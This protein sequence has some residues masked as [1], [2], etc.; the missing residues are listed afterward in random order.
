MKKITLTLFSLLFT[1]GLFAQHQGIVPR[2][3]QIKALTERTDPAVEITLGEITNT[4][5][6]AG[7]AP[8]AACASYFILMDEQARME[9][10]SGMFGVPID[11]LVH[12]WGI[13]KT[14]AYTHLWIE[15]FAGTEYT[16]YVSPVDA[17]GIVFP[18]QT[19]VLTTLTGGGSGVAEVDVQVSEITATTAR[20]IATPN[21]ETALFH[22][23]LIT[24]DYYNEIGAEAAIEFFKSEPPYYQ[25]DDYVWPGLNPAT[26][27]YALAIGQNGEGEWGSATLV[28]FTT[29]PLVGILNH[30]A[31]PSTI[32][33]FPSPG[34]GTFTFKSMNGDNGKIR[35]YNINGQMVHE[36]TVSGSESRINAG[37]LTNG[38][39]QL[40][41]TSEKSAEIATQKLIIS[42]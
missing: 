19:L 2:I 20:L 37:G 38:L 11:T 35:I 27:Y 31:Q 9:M 15:K 25:T 26:A 33:L 7:F 6:E 18:M 1:L 39:Y 36:Q 32:S 40:V 23:G 16:I 10:F 13:L 4:T 21:E 42:K 34:N 14:E 30:D 24:V 12:M 5:V 41:F 3:P 17:S 28:E 8:N 22:D 29:L